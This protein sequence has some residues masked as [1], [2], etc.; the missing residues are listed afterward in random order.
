[1]AARSSMSLEQH[2]PSISERLA[3]VD[4]PAG[5]E[6]VA[7]YLRQ[8]PYPHSSLTRCARES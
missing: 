8:G 6:R 5:R 1:M 2:P 3:S 7:A 4:S